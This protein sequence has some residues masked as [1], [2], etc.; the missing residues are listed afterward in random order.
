MISRLKDGIWHGDGLAAEVSCSAAEALGKIGDSHAVKPLVSR[1]KAFNEYPK[2]RRSAA[3]ALGEIGD[4]NA[5]P[6]L[7]SALSD[8]YINE[9]IC[10]AL[11]KMD[12]LPKS[13]DE[14]VYSWIVAKDKYNLLS[15]WEQTKRV[16]LNDMISDEGRKIEN[17]VYTFICLGR[18]EIIDELV[19][20]LDKK[21]NKVMAETC[22]NCGNIQLYYAAKRWAARHGYYISPGSG[23]CEASWGIW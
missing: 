21:G 10:S 14:Q 8:W 17:A 1:M 9:E 15:Q 5:I 11:N 13:D 2:V 20:I 18:E 4:T 6:H 22:L 12:W 3:E 19:R 16:L 23:S 7:V